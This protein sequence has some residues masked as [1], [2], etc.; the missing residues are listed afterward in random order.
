MRYVIILILIILLVIITYYNKETFVIKHINNTNYEEIETKLPTNTLYNNLKDDIISD[1][2][3][4]LNLSYFSDNIDTASISN[5]TNDILNKETKDKIFTNLIS[6]N[7]YKNKVKGKRGDKGDSGANRIDEELLAKRVNLNNEILDK[8][9]AL[10]I[11]N[12]NQE[13][14]NLKGNKFIINP[15]ITKEQAFS[16]A[17]DD[18]VTLIPKLNLNG[19]TVSKDGDFIKIENGKV[20][21]LIIGDQS[22]M[23]KNN[24]ININ[25][26][27]ILKA[28]VDNI[29]IDSKSIE[30]GPKGDIGP[31]GESGFRIQS[32]QLED[33][34]INLKTEDDG[35]F[36]IVFDE[37]DPIN[38]LYGPIGD[39]G[40]IGADGSKGFIGAGPK[41]ANYNNDTL[42][43]TS[44][45]LSSF[46]SCTGD[47]FKG[48]T[49]NKG[50]KGVKGSK[51]AKGQNINN[52]NAYLGTDLS[53][54]YFR[55]DS[56]SVNGELKPQKGPKGDVGTKGKKGKTFD[57]KNIENKQNELL[58]KKK[59][60]FKQ[61]VCLDEGNCFNN[62]EYTIK[63]DYELNLLYNLCSFLK[64]DGRKQFDDVDLVDF[65]YSSLEQY[66]EH[67][68]DSGSDGILEMYNNLFSDE[69]FSKVKLCLKAEIDVLES[70]YYNIEKYITKIGVKLNILDTQLKDAPNY[71]NNPIKIKIILE[72]EPE[73]LKN[74]YLRIKLEDIGFKGTRYD[75]LS[76][77]DYFKRVLMYIKNIFGANPQN[78]IYGINTSSVLNSN[79]KLFQFIFNNLDIIKVLE[80]KINNFFNKTETEL[81]EVIKL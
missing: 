22:I 41:G 10:N 26:A 24:N 23:L 33:N 7:K 75:Q 50:I 3:D 38:N 62:I 54:I 52:L 14:E 1:L 28:N 8:N 79:K 43:L 59:I 57:I 44:P 35:D 5:I 32:G 42:R 17:L 30:V 61:N 63:E 25:N 39:K 6:D 45:D 13:R 73:I 2:K 21:K 60:N 56:I 16:S 46:I 51:G 18:G 69:Y 11:I 58:F 78:G 72:K 71:V 68:T 29:T 4:E 47:K 9:K 70:S 81:M 48:E 19:N 20:N 53:G 34:Y 55:F 74:T 31:K 36:D 64:I 67:I 80:N 40:D 12:F 65:L 15:D 37:S 66:H 77:S 76:N 49:G 27:D